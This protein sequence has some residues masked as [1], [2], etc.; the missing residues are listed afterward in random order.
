MSMVYVLA[1]NA[2]QHAI[3]VVTLGFT[4]ADSILRPALLPLLLALTLYVL[5]FNDTI[6]N[7]VAHGLFNFNAVGLF[8][9]YLDCACISRWSFSA[10]GPTSKAG[11]YRNVRIEPRED[12][13]RASTS[14][15]VLH[16]LRFGTSLAT[17][18]RA[19][20]TP[21]Q[22]KG[23]PRFKRVP[24]RVRFVIGTVLWLAFDLLTL[25]AMSLPR[26][27]GKEANVVNFAW[28][29]VRLLSRIHEVSA[30]EMTRRTEAVLWFWFR[31]YFTLQALHRTL[32]IVGVVTGVKDVHRW[33]PT[34]G[35]LGQTY[36]LRRFW[37]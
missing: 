34:F 6:S 37:G 22:V 33:P 19:A 17:T 1:C 25:D 29:R 10:G 11:G 12:V 18:W 23:T 28:D 32:A 2:L 15:D 13:K 16:R 30:E 9:Q 8:F 7:P 3:F 14:Y 27:D 21:W 35:P 24:N 26:G 31:T 20:G 4:S 36:T 5:P